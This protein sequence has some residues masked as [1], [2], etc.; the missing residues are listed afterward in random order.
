MYINV[1]KIHCIFQLQKLVI[2]GEIPC[3][4]EE[5]ATLA[6][7]Q[8]HLEEAWPEHNLTNHNSKS[9]LAFIPGKIIDDKLLP[10]SSDP[11]E[12][13]RKRKELIRNN[14]AGR[15]TSSRR[16]GRLVRQLSCVGDKDVDVGNQID[17]YKYLPPDFHASKKIH[18]LM[19]VF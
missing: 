12:N 6:S 10:K 14:R 15:I 8:L 1:I 7:I 13:L 4:K 11:H 9:D 5:V 3:S 2:S 16:K 19:Q 18:S 17:L